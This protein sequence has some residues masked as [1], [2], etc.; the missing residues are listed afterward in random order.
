M[1]KIIQSFGKHAVAF[2]RVN[3]L[4]VALRLQE[5]YVTEVSLMYGL[6]KDVDITADCVALNDRLINK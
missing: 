2:F 6:F 5:W 3:E 1:L 4:F